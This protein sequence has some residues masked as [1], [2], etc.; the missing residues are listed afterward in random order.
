MALNTIDLFDFHLLLSDEEQVRTRRWLLTGVAA[1]LLCTSGAVD[2]AYKCIGPDEKVSYQDKPC[3]QK[4]KESVLTPQEQTTGSPLRS[5]GKITEQRI[6]N[7]AYRLLYPRN[8][9]VAT[10]Q[11]TDG[12][13]DIR[14]NSPVEHAALLVTVY[15]RNENMPGST[16]LTGVQKDLETAF[17]QQANGIR[18]MEYAFEHGPTG[19]RGWLGVFEDQ[20]TSAGPDWY[21]YSTAG[22]VVTADALLKFT[23]FTDIIHTPAHKEMLAVMMAGLGR[24]DQKIVRPH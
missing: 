9:Q 14:I 5:D 8:W 10:K 1:L 13:H 2:A 18:K 22:V 6:G 24:V 16:V 7:S 4:S 20:G 21:V 19:G 11:L 3:P 12:V 17:G 15:E 23:A